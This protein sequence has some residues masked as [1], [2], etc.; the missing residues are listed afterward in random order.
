MP[1]QPLRLI[2]FRAGSRSSTTCSCGPE[3]RR[4]PYMLNCCSAGTWTADSSS[5]AGQREAQQLQ[6]FLLSYSSNKLA[7]RSWQRMLV[8]TPSPAK[9]PPQKLHMQTV[10][11]RARATLRK[12]CVAKQSSS[13]C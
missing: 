11:Q 8:F 7:A 6:D 5:A 12:C 3:A 2:H 10:L 13:M 1:W 9:G 4:H